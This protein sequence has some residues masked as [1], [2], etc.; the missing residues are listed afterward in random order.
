MFV[1]RQ[2]KALMFGSTLFLSAE[3]SA[4]KTKLFA[5][6]K[7]RCDFCR[8]TKRSADKK[9]RGPVEHTEA[10]SPCW[11]SGVKKQS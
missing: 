3:I 5:D 7:K 6:K 2:K 4:D 9:K 10:Q 8:Q 1:H 11:S